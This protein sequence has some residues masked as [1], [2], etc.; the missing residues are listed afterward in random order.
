M[1]SFT[2]PAPHPLKELVLYP[3]ILPYSLVSY[4]LTY[5]LL[6]FV[7]GLRAITAGLTH[8]VGPETLNLSDFKIKGCINLSEDKGLIHLGFCASCATFDRCA[9]NE[10]G[11]QKACL[12]QKT[13]VSM[14]VPTDVM[15]LT[16]D[17]TCGTCNL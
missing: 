14:S 3:S 10:V 8:V 1:L 17:L 4:P 7:F 15:A 16:S 12:I 5:T 6:S 13:A 2:F 9:A 11:N